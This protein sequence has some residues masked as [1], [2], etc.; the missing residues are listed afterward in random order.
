MTTKLYI[1]NGSVIAII[2]IIAVIPISAIIAI[3]TI[4]YLYIYLV[5]LE[6]T[7]YNTSV[8]SLKTFA[9]DVII[10]KELVCDFRYKKIT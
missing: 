8:Y 6:I 1:T 9:H 4:R 2:S 10:R 5:I 3:I 7:Q